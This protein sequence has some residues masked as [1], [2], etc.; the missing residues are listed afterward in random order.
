MIVL[1]EQAIS[2]SMILLSVV[3]GVLCEMRKIAVQEPQV[4][5]RLSYAA[6]FFSGLTSLFAAGG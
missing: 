4:I 5:L 3:V 2:L 6:L 1:I